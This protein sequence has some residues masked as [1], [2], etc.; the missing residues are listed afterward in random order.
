MKC[1][2]HL[3]LLG[4]LLRAGPSGGGPSES[5]KSKAAVIPRVWR[6]PIPDGVSAEPA[7]ASP[8]EAAG[9]AVAA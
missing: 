9:L 8:R 6:Q 3:I 5:P 1:V 2:G 7:P 4:G